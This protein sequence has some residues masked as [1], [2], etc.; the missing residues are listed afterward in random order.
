MTDNPVVRGPALNVQSYRRDDEMNVSF[1]ALADYYIQTDSHIVRFDVLIGEN[2]FNVGFQVRK[3]HPGQ[4][5]GPGVL[6][7][8]R[9]CDGFSSVVN[10]DDLIAALRGLADRIEQELAAQ[11]V[12]QAEA[13]K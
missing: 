11:A 8:P 6:A 13:T 12:A 2:Q 9:N 10:S 4:E 5:R 1:R 3:V 7:M